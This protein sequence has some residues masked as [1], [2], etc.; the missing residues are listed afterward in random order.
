MACFK[1][2]GEEIANVNMVVNVFK[3]KGEIMREILSPLA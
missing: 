1:V 3:K 2:H